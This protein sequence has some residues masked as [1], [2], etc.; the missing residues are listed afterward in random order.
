MSKTKGFAYEDVDASPVKSFFV[1]MLTRD[2][3]L[4]DAILDLLD[5]CV[6][7]IL[8][9]KP[10]NGKKPYEGYW[11]EIEFK[12]DY[13]SIS[14]NCG[15]IP[16]SLHKYAFRMGRSDERPKDVSGTVGAYGIGMKR[17]V[18][19]MGRECLI[20]TQNK[21]HSY[22][23]DITP[24]WIDSEDWEIPVKAAKKTSKEDG[25]IVYIG[26]LYPNIS[27]R[28]SAG[29]R[30]FAADLINMIAA[31]YAFI[32]DKG[33]EVKVNGVSVKPK[34]TKLIFDD[35][36]KGIKPFIFE[37]SVDGVDVFLAVGFTR[38][39]PSED[40][41]KE[42]EDEAK[43]S[44]LDAGW[45]V[46]CNDRAVLYCDRSE[47][48]GWGEAGIAR[49]HT[50]FIAISGIVEFKSKSDP[51]KLPTTTTK[52]GI[53]SNSILYLQVKNKMREGMKMFIDYT[54]QWKGQSEESKKYIES[55]NALSFE[56]IKAKT[57]TSALKL[58]ET[59][60][61]MLPGKQLKP[62]LPTPKQFEVKTRR[63]AYTKSI[64]DIELVAE[65]LFKDSEVAPAKVGEK[66]FDIIL[67]S[68]K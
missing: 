26:D 57:K 23:V 38:P 20:S 53:D 56:E 39:I 32:I 60:K 63:V 68:A 36:Q 52:R 35:K 41:A 11:A 29:G 2:I 13:F 61:T 16:W 66:C 10:G 31:H 14:D 4:E 48:T 28:F 50:Q 42:Q 12:K 45:T 43:Y 7:G 47:L 18:F 5:N 54:N 46:L 51:R 65:H 21:E 59:K 15:G 67:K 3:K 33:F 40:E 8:R 55:G 62:V 30:A 64:S 25:T 27:E 49:Y 9:G 37:A 24:A 6:D 34:P 22:E 19:K 58:T 17:A 1:T 44:S